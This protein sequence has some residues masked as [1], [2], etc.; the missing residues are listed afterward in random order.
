MTPRTHQRFPG[1]AADL[2]RNNI[3]GRG[4]GGAMLYSNIPGLSGAQLRRRQKGIESPLLVSFSSS[5]PSNSPGAGR[6]CFCLAEEVRM[7]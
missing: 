7:E 4:G 5:V 1:F 3:I 2:K 6:D